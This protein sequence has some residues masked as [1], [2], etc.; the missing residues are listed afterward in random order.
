MSED[1]FGRLIAAMQEMTNPAKASVATV[2]TK[3]GGKYTYKYETLDQVLAAVRPPL[4]AHGIGLTQGQ[5]W[6]GA[7]GGYVLRTC[8]FD[9]D[10]D[11]ELDKRPVPQMPDAQAYGSWETYMR[12]YA[13]R[14]AFGLTGEDDDGAAAVVRQQ[15]TSQKPQPRP[16]RNNADYMQP[17]RE[18][19]REWVKARGF[20]D[21]A[22]GADALAKAVGAS[23]MGSI[24]KAQAIKAVALMDGET[25]AATGQTQGVPLSAADAAQAV[26][27]GYEKAQDAQEPELYDTDR[28]W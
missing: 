2:P 9:D 11:V 5:T 21:A 7:T 1:F 18:R 10:H 24:T 12:R 20:A 27:D 13:L 19:F 3:R 17:V 4:L 22:T 6:D 14:T 26:V 16:Q 28:E 23:S 25:R 8:V 15:Q